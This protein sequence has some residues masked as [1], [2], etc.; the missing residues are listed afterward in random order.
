MSE[1]IIKRKK[2]EPKYISYL[3]L[4]WAV[5]LILAVTVTLLTP[6]T[7]KNRYYDLQIEASELAQKAMDAIKTKKQELNI[8]MSDKDIYESGMIGGPH[9]KKEWYFPGM[10]IITT[11]GVLSA[12][13]TAVNPNFAAVYID[14]FKEAGLKENDQIAI[15]TSGSFPT[16]NISALAA[17]QTFGLK[18]CLMS[19]IGAST[20]GATDVEFTFFDM[21]EYLYQEGIIK[22]RID[23]VSFGGAN[24]DG[25]EFDTDIYNQIKQ[26]IDESGIPFLQESNFTQNVQKRTELILQKCPNTKLLISV[27]GTLVAMGEGSAVA[28]TYKGLVK[29]TYQ[30]THKNIDESK[31]GLLDTFLRKDIPV[32][33]ML[34]IKGIALDYGIEY[35]PVNLPTIG[36]GKAYYET[37]YN[38][39]VP[40][41]SIVISIGLLVFYF[42]YNKKTLNRR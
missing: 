1:M 26:R 33:Q 5:L 15:I 35:D 11:E 19:S 32:V 39:I 42:I 10:G 31:M 41:L 7:V 36:T 9:T 22:Y 28:S 34:N 8:P 13:R 40:I 16:L 4:I 6:K 23:Y 2:N 25:K 20:Y 24:D 12:K 3:L 29:P 18:V 30:N 21:A 14:M 38:M 17:A 27:G 37:S